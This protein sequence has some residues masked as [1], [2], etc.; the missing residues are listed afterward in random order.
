[1]ILLK[2]INFKERPVSLF[3]DNVDAAL[4]KVNQSIQQR[5]ESVTGLATDNT[6]PQNPVIEIAVDGVTVTGEGT[7]DSP[8]VANVAGS[9][10]LTNTHILVGN[11]SNIATDV[12]MSGDATMANTGAL[13]LAS[14]G[15]TPGSYTNTSLTVDAKGRLTAASS[16]SAPTMPNDFTNMFLLMGG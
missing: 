3:Q 12:A 1:M 10:A 14:T 11:V 15:V 8:L 16:G 13:T 5:V 4:K 2:K 9:A 7:E 6:D